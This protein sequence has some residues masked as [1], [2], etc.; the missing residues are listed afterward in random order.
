MFKILYSFVLGEIFKVPTYISKYCSRILRFFSEKGGV[1]KGYP[2]L[3]HG[4][5]MRAVC[6]QSLLPHSFPLLRK[7]NKLIKV[8]SQL[9]ALQLFITFVKFL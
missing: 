6:T 5:S 7:I 9:R 8:T 3:L 1:R 4:C 2:P